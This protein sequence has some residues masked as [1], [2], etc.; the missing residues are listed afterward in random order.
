MKLEWKGIDCVFYRKRKKK[1]ESLLR[2]TTFFFILGHFAFLILIPEIFHFLSSFWIFLF[3]NS[4]YIKCFFWLLI[5][6]YLLLNAT[7]H[8]REFTVCL[9]FWVNL[10]CVCSWFVFEFSYSFHRSHW[11][12]YFLILILSFFSSRFNDLYCFL[13][14]CGSFIGYKYIF[15]GPNVWD[16][17][18]VNH[19]N[20][21]YTL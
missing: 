3:I 8:P 19:V 4:N 9:F 15:F 1:R 5:F 11:C 17:W 12:F 6:F 7:G 13:R 21:S 10:Q 2:A 18:L 14:Q 16:Q 20:D